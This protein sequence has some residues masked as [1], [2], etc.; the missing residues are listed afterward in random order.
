MKSIW[1]GYVWITHSRCFDPGFHYPFIIK[2]AITADACRFSA[3]MER[4][5]QNVPFI[6][7]KA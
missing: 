1:F 3:K 5:A 4:E 7:P 6:L 2:G